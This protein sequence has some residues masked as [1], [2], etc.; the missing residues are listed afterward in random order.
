MAGT[1]DPR[2]GTDLGPY[3]I[4][5]LIGRGGM[6]VVYRAMDTRLDRRVAL[7]VLTPELAEDETFRARFLRESRLAASIDDPNII[8]VYEAGEVGGTYF[9]AMRFVDG[10]DL[11]SRLRNGPLAPEITVHLLGQIA[12]ALDAAHEA[13][14]VHRDVKPANI[15]IASGKGP[16]RPE[17]AYLTDFGLTKHR[18]SQTGATR[19]GSF[20]GTLDYIAPEQ[21]EGKEVDGRADQ[22]ALAC[23]AFQSLTGTTPFPR[24]NDAATLMAHLRDAPPLASSGRPELP[25]AGDG[26]LVKA[27]S[28]SPDDRY[29]SCSAFIRQLR[30]ALGVRPTEER[31]LPTAG[32]RRRRTL[33]LAGVAAL[34]I[35]LL[36]GGALAALTRQGETVP[37]PSSDSNPDSGGAPVSTTSIGPGSTA[38]PSA[39]EAELIAA[40]DRAA[41]DTGGCDRGPYGILG[42]TLTGEQWPAPIASVDCALDV[43]SGSSSIL[44]RKFAPIGSGAGVGNSLSLENFVNYL[45]D[46]IANAP[47]GDCTATS[48]AVGSWASGGEHAGAIVCYTDPA[49]GDAVVYWTYQDDRVLIKATNQRGNTEALRRFAE[50]AMRFFKP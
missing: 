24:D 44:V 15:L 30:D 16:D 4:E 13:G 2:V 14:L 20:L 5:A 18:G 6:G 17:H 45:A 28:K 39:G 1:P 12:S 36:A 49:S 43:E 38:F 21:I 7:K 37:S 35:V 29:A 50:S 11:E 27:M 3:R 33:L 19:A 42:S 10:T 25:A 9:L 31:P 23:V 41:M 40:L 46:R 47:S 22:Y 48:P 34:A 26:V 8:P 32:D